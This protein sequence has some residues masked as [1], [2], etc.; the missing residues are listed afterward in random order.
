MEVDSQSISIASAIGPKNNFNLSGDQESQ[1]LPRELLLSLGNTLSVMIVAS[2][3]MIVDSSRSRCRNRDRSRSR[4]RTRSHSRS[5]RLYQS[6][7]RSVSL[8]CKGKDSKKH[9]FKSS[10]RASISRK[11]ECVEYCQLLGN[12]KPT[13]EFISFSESNGEVKICSQRPDK[14]HHRRDRSR[15][16]RRS[17]GRSCRSR[18]RSASKTRSFVKCQQDEISRSLIE[19]EI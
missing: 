7:S 3:Q 10:K 5:R 9:Y 12:G 8:H 2:E 4:S 6:R 14:S 15:S 11:G 1:H 16:R 17:I 19:Q 13:A 18:S